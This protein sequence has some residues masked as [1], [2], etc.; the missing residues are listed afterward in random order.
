MGYGS[1]DNYTPRVIDDV[2]AAIRQMQRH[3]KPRATILVGHSG[4]A[5]I[6][7]DL[8]GRDPDIANAA[9]LVACGCDPVDRRARWMAEQ[10]DPI[11]DKPNPSLLP[12]D[13]AA[14][15]S[16]KVTVR[17]I[18]GAKDDNALPAYSEHYSQVLRERGVDAST[19]VL[20]GLKHDILFSPPVFAALEQLLAKY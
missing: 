20:P 2:A 8:L 6:V 3:L 12:L 13:M 18:V 5:A 17:L 16:P 14:K 10:P 7:A 4:G 1:A 19:T 9:L 11:F 15:V